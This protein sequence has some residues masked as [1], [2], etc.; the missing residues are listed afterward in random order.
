VPIPGRAYGRVA[1]V[2]EV[3]VPYVCGICQFLG[4][5]V[6]VRQDHVVPKFLNDR[7]RH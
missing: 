7:G 1:D 6:A 2:G 3:Y 4:V 5:V